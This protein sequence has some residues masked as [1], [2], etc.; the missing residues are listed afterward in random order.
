MNQPTKMNTN[1]ASLLEQIKQTPDLKELHGYLAPVLIRA[2]NALQ[3]NQNK[4][5]NEADDVRKVEN[6]LSKDLPDSIN[7]YL[8]MPIDYRNDKKINEQHSPRELLI[9]SMDVLVVALKEIEQR[10]LAIFEKKTVIDHK[11][12]QEKYGVEVE[13]ENQFKSQFDWN[14]YQKNH[15]QTLDAILTKELKKDENANIQSKKEKKSFSAFLKIIGSFSFY[16]SKSFAYGWPN[17][18]YWWMTQKMRESNAQRD[19]NT[20]RNGT[21]QTKADLLEFRIQ[22]VYS[23]EETLYYVLT[24]M[25]EINEHTRHLKVKMPMRQS[26]AENITL[27]SE[28]KNVCTELQ[29]AIYVMNRKNPLHFQA[30]GIWDFSRASNVGT[31]EAAIALHRA[32]HLEDIRIKIGRGKWETNRV[33]IKQMVMEEKPEIVA[34]Y[35]ECLAMQMKLDNPHWQRALTTTTYYVTQRA[36]KDSWFKEKVNLDKY[37]DKY[38][39]VS[40]SNFYPYQ[41]MKSLIAEINSGKVLDPEM[42]AIAEKTYAEIKA[43]KDYEQWNKV[44]PTKKHHKIK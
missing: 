39:L 8:K 23:K 44:N 37:D 33:E 11:V 29:N 42:Q 3:N 16:R 40:D 19:L 21:I 20:S 31:E 34:H 5:F 32:R 14:S 26:L 27:T 1:P 22:E 25:K 35:L 17:M 7:N 41:H 9:K 36:Q 28:L 30:G 13:P 24:L 18:E 15:P 2:H 4:N 43:K 12:F 38:M 10:N 6:I